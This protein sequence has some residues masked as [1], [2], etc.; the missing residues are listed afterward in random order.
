[1]LFLRFG[2]MRS[3]ALAGLLLFRFVNAY[4]PNFPIVMWGILKLENV[5]GLTGSYGKGNVGLNNNNH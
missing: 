4:P 3:K 5:L 1:M 2:L